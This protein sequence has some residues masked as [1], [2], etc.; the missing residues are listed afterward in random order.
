MVSN[1]KSLFHHDDTQ[2]AQSYLFFF[3]LLMCSVVTPS[4]I[5]ALQ[6]ISK[7]LNES[8]ERPALSPECFSP[9]FP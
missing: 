3:Q 2:V 5:S 8:F 1:S 4:C 7:L 6:G 9:P